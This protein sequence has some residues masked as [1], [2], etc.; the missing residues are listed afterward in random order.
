MKDRE[1]RKEWSTWRREHRSPST[2]HHPLQPPCTSPP[3]TALEHRA[4]WPLL[5]PLLIVPAAYPPHLL[6][7]LFPLLLS[8]PLFPSLFS[9]LPLLFQFQCFALLRACW[10]LIPYVWGPHRLTHSRR[11]FFKDKL[12]FTMHLTPIRLTFLV[13]VSP[14]PFILLRTIR[15]FNFLIKGLY[16]AFFLIIRWAQSMYPFLNYKS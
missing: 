16:F 5:P 2:C 4:H 14:F 15:L 3:I 9:F 13:R 12:Y 1:T 8:S 10:M 11:N 7:F 6:S